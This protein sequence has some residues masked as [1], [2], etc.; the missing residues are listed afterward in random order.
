[1]KL[2]SY[3]YKERGEIVRQQI[4]E[5]IEKRAQQCVSSSRDSN[6]ICEKVEK[7]KE[8]MVSR[9]AEMIKVK[10]KGQIDQVRKVEEEIDAVTYRVH[11][12]Y[13]IQQGNHMY[14]EEKVEKRK[15]EFYKGILVE[16][17]EINQYEAESVRETF[18]PAIGLEE[19]GEERGGFRYNRLKVVQ[20]A[21]RWWNDYNP[22]FKKFDVDCTN[23]ISQCLH[24][25]GAQ[26]S[27]YPDR[28][29]GWWMRNNNW[30]YSWSVANALRLYLPSFQNGV[31][32][33]GSV[34]SRAIIAG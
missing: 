17:V 33:K 12:Q 29:K 10:A 30:S 6:A 2:L 9:N 14:V 34:Q 1:M 7:K 15:A 16:D 20:Y 23:Y 18:M 26:M 25:G 21:E 32:S 28:G 3:I 13:L 24:A 22:A 4:V 5:L 8:A 31:E 19:A 27:G 11:F